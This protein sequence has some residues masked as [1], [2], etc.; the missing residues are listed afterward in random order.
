[1]TNPITVDTR[2]R[3]KYVTVLIEP[4]VYTVATSGNLMLVMSLEDF[5]VFSAGINNP[6]E[7]DFDYG[8]E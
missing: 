6:V 4:C 5:E 1:M 7:V 2:V 8:E 3:G